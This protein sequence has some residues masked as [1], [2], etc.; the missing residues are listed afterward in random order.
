LDGFNGFLHILCIFYVFDQDSEL[1]SPNGTGN[2]SIVAYLYDDRS[3][4]SD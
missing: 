2:I 3:Q 1:I 4:T